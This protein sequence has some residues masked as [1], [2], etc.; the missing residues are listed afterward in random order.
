MFVVYDFY[1]NY[2]FIECL[3][4]VSVVI[5]VDVGVVWVINF[6]YC[7]IVIVEVVNL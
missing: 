5:D 2:V 6:G 1:C 4:N 7:G 3:V